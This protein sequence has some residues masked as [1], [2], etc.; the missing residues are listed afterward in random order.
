MFC[1]WTFSSL[2]GFV[3]LPRNR[4]NLDIL[5]A[6]I[7]A[8]Y[9]KGRQTTCWL[10]V[11]NLVPLRSGLFGVFGFIM[12]GTH[13]RLIL[14]NLTTVEQMKIRDMK[15]RESDTLADMYSMCAFTKKRK[16]RARWDEEWGRLAL[17]GNIWWL[18]SG[19]KN[20][21]SVMGK[22]IWTWLRELCELIVLLS[23]N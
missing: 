12:S 15:D 17:E 20:W 16:M 1:V 19:R 14:L 2:L 5:M 11:H 13:I 8:L 22:S 7:I 9:V 6:V 21:E 4:D 18:G 23:L 3:V 10:E